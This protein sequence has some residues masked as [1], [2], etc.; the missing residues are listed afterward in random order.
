MK[1]LQIVGAGDISSAALWFG[2]APRLGLHP[3]PL[4]DY[5]FNLHKVD[6]RF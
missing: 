4:I 1:Q 2:R 3:Q 6:G 5:N